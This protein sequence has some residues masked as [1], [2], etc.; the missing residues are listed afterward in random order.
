MIRP[1]F[2]IAKITHNVDGEMLVT[3]EYDR[4][5][6]Q[7][8]KAVSKHIEPHSIFDASIFPQDEIDRLFSYEVVRELSESELAL[9][10]RIFTS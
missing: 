6:N 1:L 9:A 7:I 8:I 2:A 5:G 10:E 3:G 4:Q